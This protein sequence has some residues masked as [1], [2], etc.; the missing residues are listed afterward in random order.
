MASITLKKV[1]TI[2]VTNTLKIS[3]SLYLKISMLG[4]VLFTWVCRTSV[5]R[6]RY[7]PGVKISNPTGW[8]FPP[9]V[10]LSAFKTHE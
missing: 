7:E 5:K 3:F 2:I 6:L 9:F 4:Q 8:S 10:G 1:K